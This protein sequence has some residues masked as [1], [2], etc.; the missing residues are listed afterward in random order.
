MIYHRFK[1]TYRIIFYLTSYLLIALVFAQIAK[2]QFSSKNRCTS[3]WS[4]FSFLWFE[5]KLMELGGKNFSKKLLY[6]KF[7]IDWCIYMTIFDEFGIFISFLFLEVAT[8]AY[9]INSESAAANVGIFG[10]VWTGTSQHLPL[11]ISG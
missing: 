11:S 8:L 6:I 1:I 3:T 7:R 2:N 4:P 10:N 5:G 9:F